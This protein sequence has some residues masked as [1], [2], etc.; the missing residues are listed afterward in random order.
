MSLKCSSLTWIVGMLGYSNSTD[1][2]ARSGVEPCALNSSEIGSNVMG[3]RRK[4]YCC[5]WTLVCFPVGSGTVTYTT[6][7]PSY[8]GWYQAPPQE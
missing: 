7:S 6:V 1:L 4:R 5:T 2:V 8:C 3:H